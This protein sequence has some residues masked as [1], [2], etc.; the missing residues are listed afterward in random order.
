[1]SVVPQTREPAQPPHW[2][3]DERAWL[4]TRYSDAARLLKS[5]DVSIVDVA[6][7]LGKI[8]ARMNDAFANTIL[9]IGNSHPLQNPPVHGPIRAGLRELLGDILRRWTA[10][11]IDGLATQFLRA[12]QTKEPFDA[13]E[14]V[15]RPIPATII[16]DSLGLELQEVYQCGELSRAATYVLHRD[17]HA[18]RD[19]QAMEKSASLL[20]QILKT[21]YGR[22]R[23]ADFAC[24]AFLTMAGVD[25]TT[26]L[27]G[28]VFH[29]LS[30][31]PALQ[32][33]IRNEPG[34]VNSFINEVLRNSPPLKRVIGRKAVREIEASA[35]TLPQDSLL[36]IDIESAHHDPEAYPEPERFDL[37]RDGPPTLAFGAGAHACVGVALARLEAKVLI[38][39]LLRDYAIFPAGEATLRPSRDWYEFE[40]VPIRLEGV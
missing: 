13:I 16:A 33:R 23:L 7:K 11:R 12:H 6:G 19:L 17:V 38:E 40:R 28:S 36:I 37:T 2:Q 14:A 30:Q 39:R 20:V 24:L 10:D 32:D 21:R 27:L 31:S 25:T 3:A 22:E 1:V 9:L 5:E 29:R 4:I 8:S 34:L 35:V 18:L 26:S 15:A